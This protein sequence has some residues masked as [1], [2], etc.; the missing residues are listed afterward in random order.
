MDRW[1]PMD[2]SHQLPWD[3]MA[4]SDQLPR[5]VLVVLMVPMVQLNRMDRWDP[6]DLVDPLGQPNPR[7]PRVR[8]A[9]LVLFHQ[10]LL[11][12]MALSDQWGQWTQL[13]RHRSDPMG[14]EVPEDPMDR[15]GP[16]FLVV[17]MDPLAQTDR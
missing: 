5:S 10:P 2:R 16:E 13:H 12:P 1:D 11:G 4:P 7:D 6:L 17:L 3:P 8:Q 9:Q 14:L 15:L